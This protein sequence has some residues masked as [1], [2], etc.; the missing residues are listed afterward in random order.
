MLLVLLG[1]LEFPTPCQDLYN[2]VVLLNKVSTAEHV[3]NEEDKELNGDE[4]DD[5]DEEDE[6]D[7]DNAEEDFDAYDE[8]DL[9]KTCFAYVVKYPKGSKSIVSVSLVYYVFSSLIP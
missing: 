9:V 4:D 2:Q 6:I 5:E 1:L 8:L 7:D 3:G